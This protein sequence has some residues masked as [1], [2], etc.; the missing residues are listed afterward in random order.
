MIRWKEGQKEPKGTG[1]HIV[2]DEPAKRAGRRQRSGGLRNGIR[3]KQIE[4]REDDAPKVRTE[5]EKGFD[6]G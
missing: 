3:I 2:Q 5:T 4:R 1:V 6:V